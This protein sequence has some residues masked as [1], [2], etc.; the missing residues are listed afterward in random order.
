[1]RDGK[2]KDENKKI[3]YQTA[4]IFTPFTLGSIF[5]EVIEKDDKGDQDADEGT[6]SKQPPDPPETLS[7][8]EEVQGSL[9]EARHGQSGIGR[10]RSIR[11]LTLIDPLTQRVW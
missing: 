6:G 10:Y 3:T 8:F 11:W 4:Q 9:D 1:M 5:V 7:T 2:N